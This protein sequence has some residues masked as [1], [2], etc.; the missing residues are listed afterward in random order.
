[1]VRADNQK[2][3]YN[4]EKKPVQVSTWKSSMQGAARRVVVRRRCHWWSVSLVSELN[5]LAA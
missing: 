4:W 1:M 2:Y 5:T 3:I